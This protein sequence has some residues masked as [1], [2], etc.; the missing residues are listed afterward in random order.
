MANKWPGYAGPNDVPSYQMSGVPF[1][2]SS[3]G[4][5]ASTTPIKVTFPYVTKFFAVSNLTGNAD[6]RVGFTEAGVNATGG[7][8]GSIDGESDAN[9][10]NYFV[11]RRETAT[12][13]MEIRC[14]ELWFR[15]D[16]ATDVAFSLL[17]GMT[18]IPGKNFPVLTGSNNY[19]GVGW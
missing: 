5:E 8:S 7:L 19:D 9:R 15:R 2:T 6:L 12:E 18:P 1:V 16:G 17:A 11:V 3:N 10:K 13:N 4:A 14:K